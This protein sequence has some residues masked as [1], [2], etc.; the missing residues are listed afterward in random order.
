MCVCVCVR[1][2]SVRFTYVCLCVCA[3]KTD[4]ATEVQ[5]GVGEEVYVCFLTW[6]RSW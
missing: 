2:V 3:H 4:V 6:M 5:M 1:A